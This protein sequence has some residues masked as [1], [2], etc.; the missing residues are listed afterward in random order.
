MESRRAQDRLRRGRSSSN[1]PFFYAGDNDYTATSL[2]PPEHLWIVARAGGKPRR[3]TCGSWT[4]A[5]TD[6]GGIFSPQIAWTPDGRSITF[7]RV[8]NTFSGDDEY[9]TLWQVDARSGSLRKL[10][11]RDEL[12][13]SPAYAPEGTRLSYWYPLGG[14]FNSENTVR[15][16]DAQRDA[17]LVP[18]LDRNVA[19]SLWFPDGKRVLLCGADGTATRFWIAALN[20]GLRAVDL[21]DLHPVCDPYSSTTFDA[22]AAAA[23]AR[24]GTIAFVATSAASARELYLLAP[25]ATA[26]R[27]LTHFNAFLESVSVGAMSELQW[28]GPGGFAEDG[29]VTRPPGATQRASN[30][31]SFC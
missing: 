11:G 21:G 1:A 29:V 10:S 3:L 27:R 2:A 6:P 15:V 30:T 4:I 18:E 12:E 19:A 13:L 14:D 28:N 26:P 22:G 20:G 17:A 5:P 9:S 25:G 16:L 23:I 7:T 31:R 8:A 24:D